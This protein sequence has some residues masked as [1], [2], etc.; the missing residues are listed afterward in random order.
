MANYVTE[1]DLSISQKVK[2]EVTNAY[3]NGTL[4]DHKGFVWVR[5]DKLHS[6][7]RTTKV[8]ANYYWV[9]IESKY[10]INFNNIDYVRGFKVVELLARR[11]EEDGVGKKG[12]NLEA[13]K[14]MYDQINTCEVVKLLRLEYNLSVKEERR[15]LKQRRI[16]LYKIEADELTGEL[17]IKKSAEFSHIR[18]A[19]IYRDRCT[20]IENGLIVNYETHRIITSHE[21]NHEEQLLSLC[22]EQG[23]KTDWYD[24]YKKFYR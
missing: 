18:S 2:K 8:N 7:L 21:I 3:L 9:N 6:I 11:I 4:V 5:R 1:I 23:W 16:R 17:L 12:A 20:D 15:T 10:K 14:F 24:E 19:S 22:K 13:S